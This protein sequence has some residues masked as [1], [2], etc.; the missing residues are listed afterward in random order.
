[1]VGLV[2]WFPSPSSLSWYNCVARTQTQTFDEIEGKHVH[3]LPHKS[4]CLIKLTI[5]E[6]YSH[7]HIETTRARLH[8]ILREKIVHSSQIVTKSIEYI[9][10]PK[11]S[12]QGDRVRVEE[13][14][15]SYTKDSRNRLVMVMQSKRLSCRV[16]H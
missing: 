6:I 5:N 9:H 3:C 15:E 8:D 16:T 7:D 4:V 1:M 10:W 14:K 13:S 2:G 12:G 11:G